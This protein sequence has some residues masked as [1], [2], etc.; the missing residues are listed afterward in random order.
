MSST[1]EDRAMSGFASDLREL[2][3]P[4]IEAA[5]DALRDLKSDEIPAS[6]RRVAAYSGGRLPPPLA[7]SM[8]TALDQD[9]WIREKAADKLDER[10]EQSAASA[11]LSRPEGWWQVVA[12]DLARAGSAASVN[13]ATMAEAARVDLAKQLDVAKSRLK[14]LKGDLETRRSGPRESKSPE[15]APVVRSQ[16]ALRAAR[17]QIAELESSL[18]LVTGEHADAELM[19]A[20]LRSRLR[21]VVREQRRSSGVSDRGSSPGG[22]PLATARALD[23]QVASAPDRSAFVEDVLI[24]ETAEAHNLDLPRGLRPDAAEAVDWLASVGE[25]MTVIVDGYN[26][27]YNIDP[28]RFTTGR[29]R[30]YLAQE[31]AR[32]RRVA[33]NARVVVVY[34]SDL[35]G[36]R[37]TR[38]LPGGVEL[39]FA[40]QEELADD[41]IVDLARAAKGAV[42]VITS[43]RD[44]R[45]RSESVGAL[46]LWSEAL[47]GWIKRRAG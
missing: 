38:I 40:H 22:D 4:A 32:L 27:L 37:D 11:F 12:D 39:H 3:A 16:Q 36:E 29:A 31:L 17:T 10:Y 20:R 34:D 8:L 35:P 24:S 43:D 41:A 7:K 18:A 15:A 14:Q 23:L 46:T 19:I 47:V 45:E 26:V 44:L 13:A 5:R 33:E 25:A 6:L 9:E 42:I 28:A 30:D 2:L 1:R 21:N